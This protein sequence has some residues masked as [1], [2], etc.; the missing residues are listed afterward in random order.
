MLRL[1]CLLLA[2]AVLILPC[3]GCGQG[4]AQL[5]NDLKQVGLG[6]HN[7]HDA[8]QQGPAN[9]E[10]FLE[11]AK[12]SN[13]PLESYQRVRDAGYEVTWGVKFSELSGGLS[14]AVMAKPPGPGPTLMFDGS[15]RD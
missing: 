4:E 15:V 8:N 10:E 3:C 14:N 5:R 12:N 7:F 9:W 2:S 13:E 1:A 6:Y 11:F